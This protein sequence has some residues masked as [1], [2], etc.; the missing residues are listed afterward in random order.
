MSRRSDSARIEAILMYIDDINEIVAKHG[1]IDQTLSEKEGEY[2][3]MMCL[4][5]IGELLGKIESSELREKLPVRLAANMR[6]VI[7]HNY[8]GVDKQ[9]IRLTVL[10]S[11]PRLKSDISSLLDG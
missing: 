7:V 1:D 2:A 4:V 9:I 10:E 11:L 3:V 6:N 5:Q 8:E